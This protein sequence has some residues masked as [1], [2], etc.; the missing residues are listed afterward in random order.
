MEEVKKIQYIG[1]N[2]LT[3]KGVGQFVD[4]RGRSWQKRWGSVL[5]GWGRW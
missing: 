5:S 1:G 4:L 3:G 2:F